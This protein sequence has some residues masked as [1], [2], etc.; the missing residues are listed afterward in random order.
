VV[1]TRPIQEPG[2]GREPALPQPSGDRA[3]AQRELAAMK[4]EHG[5]G[6][7]GG[8]LRA[9]VFGIN[10]GL[11]TNASLVVGVAAA[12]TGRQAVIL[13]GVAGLVAGAFSM[14][15]GEYISVR[16]QRELFEARIASERRRLREHAAAERHEVAV[17]FRAKGLAAQDAERVAEH[18]MADP[19]VALDLMAREEL[20]LNPEDLGSPTGVAISSFLA[21]AIGGAAPLLPY[22]VLD[23]SAAMLAALVLAGIALVAVGAATARLSERSLLL[24]ALRSL[25]VGG[26][27]TAVTYL[28]GRVVGTVVR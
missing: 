7:G 6:S 20:G 26:L 24:G 4:A 15:A 23:G 10:D 12:A 13:A 19:E 14:G 27:A 1:S 18:V 8:R 3:Q 9:A 2:A 28:V 16:T 25:A 17:I 21:F 5:G 11:V 22:I